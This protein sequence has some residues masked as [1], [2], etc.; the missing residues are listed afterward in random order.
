MILPGNS[1]WAND[2][3]VDL[4]KD[5]LDCGSLE[6]CPC[7]H[8]ALLTVAHILLWSAGHH[9]QLIKEPFCSTQRYVAGWRW[10]VG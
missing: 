8:F 1:C 3:I 7:N 9:M 10:A 2:F 6:V 4:G 5:V